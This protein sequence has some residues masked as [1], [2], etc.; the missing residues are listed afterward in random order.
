MDIS[1]VSSSYASDAGYGFS[2]MIM[3]EMDRP[4]SGVPSLW[5]QCL[6]AGVGMA[7]NV[8][9]GAEESTAVELA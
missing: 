3:Q 9:H 8:R 5:G 1:R 4:A 2:V 6:W 7:C